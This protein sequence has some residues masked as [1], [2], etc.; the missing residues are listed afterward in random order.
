M[1]SSAVLLAALGARLNREAGRPPLPSLFFLT[2]PAR[3]PDPA[4]IVRRL[5]RGA[6]VI[7]RHFGAPGREAEAERLARL[8]RGRGLHLL[9]SA[10]PRLAR[11][12]GAA[13]VHWPER[14]LPLRR[15][16]FRLETAA[17]HSRRALVRAAAAGMD[18]ALLGPVFPSNSASALRLLGPCR[19]GAL[20]RGA[21]LPAIAL[22]G[23][24]LRNARRLL[25]LGFAGLAAI[26]ALASPEPVRC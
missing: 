5:P 6:A 10:D 18:A 16:G 9:I 22:G 11:K 21:M 15:S 8:C 23:V 19:A 13:G 4:E 25:G 24:S 3:T 26:E 1:R 2:D 17:A 14:R 7:Y 12:V 20:A